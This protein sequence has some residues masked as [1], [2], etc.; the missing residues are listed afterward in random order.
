MKGII[1]LTI[2]IVNPKHKHAD[3]NHISID[4]TTWQSCRSVTNSV[5]TPVM[6]QTRHS[7]PTSYNYRLP[8]SFHKCK[9]PF[10]DAATPCAIGLTTNFR[11]LH[12]I[13]LLLCHLVIYIPLRIMIPGCCQLSHVCFPEN[14]S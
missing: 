14:I 13:R 1:I 2:N 3:E 4:K 12:Y 5:V 7:I 11:I 10:L 6:T 8:G 9:L